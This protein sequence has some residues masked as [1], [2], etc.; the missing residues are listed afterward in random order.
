LFT[1]PEFEVEETAQKKFNELLD[2]RSKGEPV[3]YLIGKKFFWDFELSVNSDVLIPR[4]ETEFLVEK[5]IELAQAIE[6]RVVEVNEVTG[7]ARKTEAGAIKL[8]DLGTGSG[9]IAIALAKQRAV[10]Q[11]TAVDKSSAALTVAKNNARALNVTNIEFLLGSWCQPLGAES[12]HLIAAN[13]PY[14]E[15]GDSHLT[16]GSL[17]FEP[18]IAL[19]ADDQGLADIQQIIEQSKACLRDGGWLLIEHGFDQSGRVAQLLDEAGYVEIGSQA[20]LA[21]IERVAFAQ[22]VK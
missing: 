15:A 7:V 12:Y 6:G 3:A 4:P 20:D 21:G 11:V 16:Q 22:W 2:R 8:A 18:Q 10:W 9:A 5:A 17:P 13:P 14:V 19:I 1:W